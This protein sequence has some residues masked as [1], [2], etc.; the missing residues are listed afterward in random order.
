MNSKISSSRNDY[1]KSYH[2]NKQEN[3]EIYRFI[4]TE[5]A[6]RYKINLNKSEDEKQWELYTEMQ[7]NIYNNFITPLLLSGYY[8]TKHKTSFDL[9]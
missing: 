6:K 1:Y 2:H 8:K 9:K 5:N 7:K 3:D 4:K